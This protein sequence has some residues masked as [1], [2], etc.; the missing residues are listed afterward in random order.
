MIHK[1]GKVIVVYALAFCL[2]VG[3]F[4]FRYAPTISYYVIPIIL[5]LLAFIIYFFRVPKRELLN[6]GQRNIIAPA[7]GKVVAI[8]EVEEPEFLQSKCQMISIFMSPVNV[9]I[10][11]NPVS[12][13]VIYHKHHAGKYLVAWHPK[14]SLDNERTTSVI[15]TG[16]DKILLRQI[17]GAMARRII[18]YHIS[19]KEV[20]QGHEMGFIRFGS[21]VDV[22]VPL[23]FEICCKIG[24]R[25]KGK[26]SLLARKR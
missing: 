20:E 15:D 10:N 17:A 14:S 16:E 11:W 25:V 12:G 26:Q 22:Y 9:H 3:G 23:S 8:E 5:T 6:K 1:E 4:L 7:D 19:D 21:R 24:D 13:K 18:N 2:I